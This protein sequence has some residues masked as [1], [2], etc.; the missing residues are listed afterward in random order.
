MSFNNLLIIFL[1][2]HIYAFFLHP[3]L[4]FNNNFDFFSKY[5]SLFLLYLSV[6]R[7]WVIIS[8]CNNFEIN[9]SS[10]TPFVFLEFLFDVLCFIL[11]ILSYYFLIF[12]ITLC[13]TLNTIREP[14]CLEF[15]C[16]WNYF[17]SKL[18]NFK[19][20]YTYELIYIYG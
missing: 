20:I 15:S 1:C 6:T 13:R 17:V 14:V 16:S 5:F 8:F 4:F 19:L 18:P 11:L 12:I 7:I 10:K 9:Q 3:I 2:F